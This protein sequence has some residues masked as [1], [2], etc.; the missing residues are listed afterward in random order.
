MILIIQKKKKRM[1]RNIFVRIVI[2]WPYNYALIGGAS[3]TGGGGEEEG[4]ERE[5]E[6]TAEIEKRGKTEEKLFRTI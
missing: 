1:K 5:K 3:V 2:N 6:E 4:G